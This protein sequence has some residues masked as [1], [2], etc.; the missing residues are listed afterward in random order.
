MPSIIGWDRSGARMPPGFSSTHST[1][2]SSGGWWQRPTVSTAFSMNSGCADSVKPSLRCDL[3][4]NL[5]QV[6]LA[7]DSGRRCA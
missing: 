1:T 7:V 6:W 2:A 5:R 3:R 4:S